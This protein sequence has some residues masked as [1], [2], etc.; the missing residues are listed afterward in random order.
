MANDL[1]QSATTSSDHVANDLLQS[2]T[3]SSDRVAN[4]LLQSATTSSD[5]VA[6]DRVRDFCVS[7]AHGWLTAI[8]LNG[9]LN[10]RALNPMTSA[11]L[12][13]VALN[14]GKMCGDLIQSTVWMSPASA[15]EADR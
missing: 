2:A 13:V 12:T 7:C 4:D 3:T 6:N 15:M 11:H 5:R 14:C 10:S 8:K 1:L 9:E